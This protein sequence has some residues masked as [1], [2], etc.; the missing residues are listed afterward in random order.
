MVIGAIYLYLIEQRSPAKLD[1]MGR[2]M[3]EG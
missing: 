3:V 2:V 1:G